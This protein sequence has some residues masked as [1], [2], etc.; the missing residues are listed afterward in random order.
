MLL[1]CNSS[2]RVSPL[3]AY[4]LSNLNVVPLLSDFLAP[5]PT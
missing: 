4:D 5:S 1:N 2:L 3:L